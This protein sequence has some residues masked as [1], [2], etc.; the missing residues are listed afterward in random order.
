MRLG[1]CDGVIWLVCL[2]NLLQL[3]RCVI[4]LSPDTESSQW[5]VNGIQ[6]TT[7]LKLLTVSNK[8]FSYQDTPLP[9]PSSSSVTPSSFPSW[10]LGLSV[11][12][13]ISNAH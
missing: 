3:L 6:S 13:A 1:W 12:T 8:A 2:I 5:Y 7:L 11:L 9:A 4:R 10:R